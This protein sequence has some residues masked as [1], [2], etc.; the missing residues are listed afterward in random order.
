LRP[1]FVPT[2][3]IIAQQGV[4]CAAKNYGIKAL[5]LRYSK[6]SSRERYVLFC[7]LLIL[8]LTI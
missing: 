8:K 3:L 2:K 5:V 1:S 4:Y 6:K 7:Y